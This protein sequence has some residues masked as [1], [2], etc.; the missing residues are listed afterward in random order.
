[1]NG[2]EVTL[3]ALGLTGLMVTAALVFLSIR[4]KKIV[5]TSSGALG[6]LQ[7]LN[8]DYKARLHYYPPIRY[9]FVDV[10]H[11][12]SKFD[13][14]DLRTLFLEKVQAMETTAQREIDERI[15]DIAVFATYEIRYEDLEARLGCSSSPALTAERFERIERMLFTRM[16]LPD[17][18]CVAAVR[19]A[20]TYTSPKGRNSYQRALEWNFDGLRYGLEEMRRIREHRT[21]TQFLRQQER[22]RMTGRLRAEILTRDG[23]RCRMCGATPAHGATLH[24]DHIVPVSHGG[25]TIPENLQTLCQDCNLGKSNVF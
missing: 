19:C 22:N 4:R 7:R 24:I 10:V 6:E 23:S 12:K 9:S 20:V 5:V 13:R 16:R 2:Y 1:V 18:V 25:R 15:S 14:Y 17:P 11:S 3:T 21:T 8:D